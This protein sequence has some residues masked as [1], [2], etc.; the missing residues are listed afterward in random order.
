ML[1]VGL[2]THIY[3]LPFYF[4]AVKNTS[5]EGSG[6]RTIPYL[7]SNSL[8]ALVVGGMITKIGWYV[9]FMWFA[10]ATFSIG[11]GLL[12]TFKV[13]T[14]TAKWIGYQI[15]T[16]GGSG[17]GVQIPFIAVQVVLSPKD[18]PTGNA[19]A[20]FVQTFG[21]AIAVSIA[22]NI[23]T[24]T[25]VKNVPA[26]VDAKKVVYAGAT[27]V[28]EIVTG[29]QL[30]GVLVAYDKAVT[31]TFILPIAAGIIALIGSA[32]VEWKSVKGVKLVA[33]GGA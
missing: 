27:H 21:G 8:C 30:Q 5:A 6:I 11:C 13:D 17:A 23:F 15:L 12:Y 32:F 25:L 31:S 1:G 3:F 20:V 2:Y 24:N 4:Q 9:P 33:P 28:R 29:A 16:G 14:S 18:L 10:A 22:Q 7:V 19:I 26:G